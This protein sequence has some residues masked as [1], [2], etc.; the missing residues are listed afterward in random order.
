MRSGDEDGVHNIQMAVFSC[1][2]DAEMGDVGFEFSPFE[3]AHPS[4]TQWH[5]CRIFGAASGL[6]PELKLV[7]L[8]AVEVPEV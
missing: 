3:V 1:F 4:L 5:L 8:G 6:R 2:C 7:I